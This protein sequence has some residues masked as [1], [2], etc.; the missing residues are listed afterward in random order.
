MGGQV[1][2]VATETW[3]DAEL[4]AAA[5]RYLQQADPALAEVVT[6]VGAIEAPQRR[7]HGFS[8]LV[9]AIAGQQ[10]SVKAANAILARIAARCRAQ[11][12]S[13]G[14]YTFTPETVLAY[15]VEELRGCG[16]SRP[17]AG[18]ILDLAAQVR[19]GR[20]DLDAMPRLSDAV[21]VAELTK[22]KGIGTWS[23]EIY[24]MFILGRPDVLP[25]GDLGIRTAVQ[26]LDGRTD[27]P[28]V[29][30]VRRRGERW[31]P[32]RS[33]AA[34]YLWRWRRLLPPPSPAAADQ[35]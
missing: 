22:V 2:T 8:T 25:A 1:A 28:S 7:G 34:I 3:F 11:Q 35:A 27:L 6:S 33:V 14:S 5:A 30:A 12:L 17:K 29:E 19:D 4:R 9:D 23:A 16:L 13:D 24:L 20:L 10:L 15:S 21:A 31:R 18:C 32:Y 26:Q